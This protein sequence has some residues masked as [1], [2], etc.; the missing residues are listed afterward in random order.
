MLLCECKDA[1]FLSSEGFVPILIHII[2]LHVCFV[3]T[4]NGVFAEEV[5]PVT[6]HHGNIPYYLLL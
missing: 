5:K 1:K 2:L 3:Y 6:C 4:G